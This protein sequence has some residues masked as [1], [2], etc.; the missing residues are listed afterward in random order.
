[1]RSAAT[2]LALAA[3]AALPAG[4]SAAPAPQ[5][6]A[7]EFPV[8][9]LPQGGAQFR[10][11]D[12]V[13][14]LSP[15]ARG[16]SIPPESLTTLLS[17]EIWAVVLDVVFKADAGDAFIFHAGDGRG[18]V[19]VSA[20]ALEALLPDGRSRLLAAG[21]SYE[22][23][24][25]PPPPPG[26]PPPP[27]TPAAGTQA[28]TTPPSWDPLSALAKSM[29]ALAGFQ[30]PELKL[31]VELHPYYR[32]AQTYDSNIY[33]VPPDQPDGRRVGGGV[34]GSW[35]TTNELGAR[36]RVPF[37]RRHK[38]EANYGSEWIHYSQQPRTNN[39]VNQ[40]AGAA[41]AYSGLRDVAVRAW[42]SYLNTEDP[43]FSEQVA[44]ERR[45][46][47]ALGAGVESS[48]SR[49]FV[50]T[51]DAQH[52]IHKYLNPAL[53]GLLNRYEASGG[54]SAGIRLQPKTRLYLAYHRSVIHY[55][56]GR[57]S[58]SRSHH[59]DVGVDGR[60]TSKVSGKAQVGAQFRR[61]ASPP[62]P[63]GSAPSFLQTQ[64]QLAFRPDSRNELTLRAFRDVNEATFAS[65]AYY[66]ATGGA[67]GAA[68][69]YHRVTLSAHGSAQVDRYP[70][71]A[72][73]GGVTATRRDGLYGAGAGLDLRVRPWLSWG[74]GYLRL[75]RRSTFAGQ[76]NYTDQRTTANLRVVF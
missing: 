25:Q 53:G 1:M 9:K 6:A 2:A 52:A 68:H 60:L 42:E 24:A 14:T 19:F 10:S 17:G 51:A 35:V 55:S 50:W 57:G 64:V 5:A 28:P 23:S 15:G 43:A 18:Q 7:P 71:A 63:G 45:F 41:Y 69:T 48:R 47:N 20:G 58:H 54:G 3:L 62:G 16:F 61:Y 75:A 76:F 32:F 30:K 4:A 56:A 44:R 36:L 33:L 59:L 73:T 70:E 8:V 37:N 12:Q 49:R 11:N 27:P 22:L 13:V 29:S 67:L 46:L 39:A 21:E 26:A 72:T 66:V 74:L 34:L 40:K 38:L 65:N 31:V